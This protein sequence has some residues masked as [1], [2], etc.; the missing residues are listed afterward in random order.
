MGLDVGERRIGVALSDPTGLI[1]RPLVVLHRRSNDQACA[2][3]AQLVSRNA[4]G[5]I[6]VGLP[7]AS[8]TSLGEQGR[9][10]LRFVRQL[11]HQVAVP[12]V[13]WDE[14]HSTAEAARRLVETRGSRARRKA[15]L[16]A[17]AAAII[18]EEWLAARSSPASA[19]SQ[20]TPVQS[21]HDSL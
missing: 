15:A 17:A 5:E 7:I 20:S 8:D 2:E 9:R 1:V 3:I 4:V 16:D 6:V 14:R 12:V 13:T 11:R 19:L 18:L 10:T 21:P